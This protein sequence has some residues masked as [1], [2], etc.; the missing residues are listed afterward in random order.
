M[1]V[2][3]PR[4]FVCCVL[5]RVAVC[6]CCCC[7]F[8]EVLRG[9]SQV[10]VTNCDTPSVQETFQV[11]KPLC[12]LRRRVGPAS[13]SR[14]LLPL[15]DSDCG[16]RTQSGLFWFLVRLGTPRRSQHPLFPSLFFF[17]NFGLCWTLPTLLRDGL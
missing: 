17:F 12:P 5:L 11:S 16:H 9:Q 3:L 8:T 13:R 15:P 1:H 2:K 14:F 10:F 4:L 7:C 6:C